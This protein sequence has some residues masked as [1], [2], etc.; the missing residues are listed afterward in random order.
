MELKNLIIAALVF[1]AAQT[2][3]SIYFPSDKAK[4]VL[5]MMELYDQKVKASDRKYPLRPQT[6]ATELKKAT[7]AAE[8]HTRCAG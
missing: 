2:A 1:V 6:T 7:V 4:C 5:A 8:A 3:S